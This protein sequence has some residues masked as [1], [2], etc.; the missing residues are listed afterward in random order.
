MKPFGQRSSTEQKVFNYR[1]SRA[2]RVV[3]NAFG[4]LSNKFQILQRDITLSVD[5]VQHVTLTCCV[6]HNFIKKHD[7]KNYII[8]IDV[9]NTE[10]VEL[11]TGLWRTEAFTTGLEP[12]R[13]HRAANEP[14]EIRNTFMHYFNEGFVRWQWEA[15]K[16]FNF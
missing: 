16:Q 1:L 15:V 13:G 3:E 9:E 6:L 2:R 8:G 10:R 7:G 12:L 11:T 5:K 4:I 14:M